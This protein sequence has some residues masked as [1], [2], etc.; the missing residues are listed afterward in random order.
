[1]IIGITGTNG[2]GKGTVVDYLKQKG[3]KHCSARDFIAQEVE[4]RG[5]PVT[6]VTL[7]QVGD[8]LRLTHA[9]GYIANEL[10]KIAQESGGD[11][12]IESLRNVGEAEYLKSRGVIIWAVDAD[13]AL[14]YERAVKRG[15]QTDHVTLEEFIAQEEVEMRQPDKH[16]MN[17][18]GVMQ[19]ADVIL[20]NNGTPEELQKQIEEALKRLM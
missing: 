3:F 20:T 18:F 11:A 13:R 14:R 6:R 1:M 10:L 9:P 4:R 8:D 12:V 5:L 2:A 17:I 15:S 16:R 19:M 7:G